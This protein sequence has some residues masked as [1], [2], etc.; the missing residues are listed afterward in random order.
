MAMAGDAGGYL[1]YSVLVHMGIWDADTIVI[2]CGTAA[3]VCMSDDMMAKSGPNLGQI[4]WYGMVWYGINLISSSQSSRRPRRR[5][6]S[7]VVYR[8]FIDSSRVVLA[9]DRV[10]SMIELANWLVGA[11]TRHRESLLLLLLLLLMEMEMMEIMEMEMEVGP[12]LSY[13]ILSD[14]I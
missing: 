12:I 3:V 1:V 4:G 11:H 7:V 9:V 6:S 10:E 5:R 8:V 13:L 14:S 2:L